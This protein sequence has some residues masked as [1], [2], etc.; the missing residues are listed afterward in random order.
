MKDID[1]RSKSPAKPLP[2]Y[3]LHCDYCGFNTI[4]S[5]NKES[6]MTEIK[7]SPVPGG[8]PYID[9]VDGKVKKQESFSRPKM[10]K[11]KKCGRGIVVKKCNVKIAAHESLEDLNARR[12]ENDNDKGH[13][14]GTAGFDFSSN[15]SPRFDR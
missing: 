1:P 11:C 8:V 5:G 13:Q 14:G 3:V 7:R 15:P 12:E 2:N 9:P 10:F 6:G 4:I